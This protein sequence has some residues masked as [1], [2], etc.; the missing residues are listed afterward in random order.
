MMMMLMMVIT[1]MI[2]VNPLYN[3]IISFFSIREQVSVQALL[4]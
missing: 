2:D 4:P 1:V 3:S